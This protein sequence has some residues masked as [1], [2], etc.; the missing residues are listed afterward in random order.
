MSEPGT[1]DQPTQQPPEQQPP[2]AQ[3][4]SEV[5]QLRAQV[6]Q[7]EAER[8]AA[9]PVA[10]GPARPG[11]TLGVPERPEGLPDYAADW[12]QEGGLK[13]DDGQPAPQPWDLRA[14]GLKIGT[15]ND[16]S[17]VVTDPRSGEITNLAAGA[18]DTVSPIVPVHGRPL[19]GPLSSDPS[20]AELGSLLAALGIETSVSEG[21]NPNNVVD[22]SVL[23]GVRRFREA[24][25]VEEDPSQWPVAGKEQAQLHVGAWTWEALFRAVKR[26]LDE[27][28]DDARQV[29]HERAV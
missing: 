11:G 14:H 7:L 26:Q 9:A 24:F 18:P 28:G 15:D 20:V 1:T 29:V 19:L 2:T 8:A 16:G 13:L 5:E 21:T 3:P 17:A 6:A 12:P 23:N 4:P 25:G 27:A 22:D 10:S